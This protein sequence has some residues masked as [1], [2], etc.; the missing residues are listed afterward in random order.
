MSLPRRLGMDATMGKKVLGPMAGAFIVLLLLSCWR[1]TSPWSASPILRSHGKRLRRSPSELP[2]LS[3][4]RLKRSDPCTRKERGTTEARACGNAD[5][6]SSVPSSPAARAKIADWE[7]R[8]TYLRPYLAR[9]SSSTL[10][11]PSL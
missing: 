8:P 11:P 5:I 10:A 4:T 6:G 7:R 1:P 3:L 2:D 9:G